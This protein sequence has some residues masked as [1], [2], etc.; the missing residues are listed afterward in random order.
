MEYLGCS[1]RCKC[2]VWNRIRPFPLALI[3]EL[4]HRQYATRIW[5]IHNYQNLYYLPWL[6][7]YMAVARRSRFN[8]YFWRIRT[9]PR[10]NQILALTVA[11]IMLPPVSGDYT[12]I[13]L[14]I[15]W[16]ALVLCYNL[17]EKRAKSAGT[18]FQFYL[19]GILNG[20]GKLRRN[21][22]HKIRGPVES[23]CFAHPVCPYRLFTHL[24]SLHQ[25]KT[26]YY[27]RL[28]QWRNKSSIRIEE[29]ATFTAS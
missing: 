9:L 28:A 18:Y 22:W 20:A 24:K 7:G 27:H 8:L 13:H 25:L 15:P 21:I 5:C 2:I 11:S 29:T 14:Y 4:T 19:H 17:V 3:K 6:Y 26:M 12:L 10:T 23:N 1:T 16:G